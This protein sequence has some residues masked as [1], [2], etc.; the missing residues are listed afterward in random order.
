M[1]KSPCSNMIKGGFGCAQ[2]FKQYSHLFTV[3]LG[4]R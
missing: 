3:N 4:N 2:V 1:L